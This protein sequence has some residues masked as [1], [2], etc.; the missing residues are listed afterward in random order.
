MTDE[1]TIAAITRVL[2]KARTDGA[3]ADWTARAILAGLRGSG[4]RPTAARPAPDWQHRDV[5]P[6]P[7]NADYLA[8]R[9]RSTP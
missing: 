1:Q 8:A 5:P 7:P 4:W 9:P 6:A 2:L 3:D